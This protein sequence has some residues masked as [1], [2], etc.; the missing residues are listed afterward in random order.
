[1]TRVTLLS[2]TL[3]Y[4]GAR[5]VSSLA[6]NRAWL[7]SVY[8]KLAQAGDYDEV[9][10]IWRVG[11]S[12][13]MDCLQWGGGAAAK[14]AIH[15]R[16]CA[17]NLQPG[18]VTVSLLS[19]KSCFCAVPTPMG[20]V[21]RNVPSVTPMQYRN[22][23]RIPPDSAIGVASVVSQYYKQRAPCQKRDLPRV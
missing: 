12:P 17:Q 6:E 3:R 18:L 16:K 23:I 19:L 2:R 7:H 9:L 11:S 5:S 20:Q 8:S 13:A 1:M 21:G 14:L 10:M 15:P 22:S 4:G